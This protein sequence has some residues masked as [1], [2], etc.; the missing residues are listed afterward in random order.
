[1]NKTSDRCGRYLA[2]G[3]YDSI[4]NMFDLSEWICART[5]TACEQVLYIIWMIFV[6]TG[7]NRNAINALSFSHD[8]EYLA[9]ANTGT[10]IDI[11]SD[12]W[13]TLATIFTKDFHSAPPKPVLLYTEFP[14][15]QLRRPLAG[16][17]R[18]T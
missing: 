17:R 2:S 8:G 10:Y 3:G 15:L 18:D 1:M 7:V 16:T 12:G 6:L 5:I 4:V 13:I 11:V 14:Q 9:I